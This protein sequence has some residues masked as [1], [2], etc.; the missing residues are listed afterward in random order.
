MNLSYLQITERRSWPLLAGML[1]VQIGTVGICLK[2]VWPSIAEL[3][4]LNIDFAYHYGVN[5]TVVQGSETSGSCGVYIARLEAGAP[6]PTAAMTSRPTVWLMSLVPIRHSVLAF[7]LAVLL[8]WCSQTVVFWLCLRMPCFTPAGRCAL[9]LAFP[10]FWWYTAESSLAGAMGWMTAQYVI[11]LL[12]LGMFYHYRSPSWNGFAAIALG[13]ALAFAL[14]PR[15]AIGGALIWPCVFLALKGRIGWKGWLATA[16]WGAVAILLNGGW[17][18]TGLLNGADLLGADAPVFAYDTIGWWLLRR[19]LFVAACAVA[20]LFSWRWVQGT[21]KAVVLATWLAAL[22]MGTYSIV[23]NFLPVVR[24]SEPPP[25]IFT[26]ILLTVALV[27]IPLGQRYGE[28]PIAARRVAALGAACLSAAAVVLLMVI[29]SPF[30][31]YLRSDRVAALAATVQAAEKEA[32]DGRL[33][34]QSDQR[35]LNCANYVFATTDI[36]VVGQLNVGRGV[37]LPYRLNLR[38]NDALAGALQGDV[39][40]LRSLAADYNLRYLLTDDRRLIDSLAHTEGVERMV[41]HDPFSLFRIDVRQPGYFA[42]GT[43]TVQTTP[44][45][46]VASALRPDGEGKIVLRYNY[47]PSLK[48]TPST[49]EVSEN[50]EG[51]IVLRN[52][53]GISHVRLDYIPRGWK[54]LF[55]RD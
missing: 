45:G 28:L 31:G 3:P 30:E 26:A 19:G 49:V 23:G 4:F 53:D 41:E 36:E 24:Y 40:P 16:G 44:D 43:G 37:R 35:G 22:A 42:A 55:S 13:W 6:L 14:H 34:V 8:C 2:E 18:F 51:F 33:L 39:G 17:F 1:L 12:L 47:S 21:N 11:A 32:R 5:R 52:L 10:A 54:N 50:A 15:S 29:H 27:C 38:K 46:L 9:A 48:P 7:N 25:A 20:G